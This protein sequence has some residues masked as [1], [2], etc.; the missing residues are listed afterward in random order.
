MIN[1]DGL[2]SAYPAQR[3]IWSA[4][5]AMARMADKTARELD[6]IPDRVMNVLSTFSDH[7]PFRGGRRA[8]LP[9]LEARLPLLPLPRRRSRAGR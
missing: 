6:W 5:A 3:E 2:A 7:G 9:D 8:L 4:D 1:L